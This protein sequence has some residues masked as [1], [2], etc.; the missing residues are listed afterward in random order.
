MRRRRRTL[1][2]SAARRLPRSAPGRPT[3][4]GRPRRALARREVPLR[5]V[6]A[7][8]RRRSS[9]WPFAAAPSRAGR[10]RRRLRHP[11]ADDRPAARGSRATARARRRHVGAGRRRRF[12]VIDTRT[13][14]SRPLRR[15]T[16]ASR[17][18]RSRRTGRRCTSRSTSTRQREPLRRARVRPRART[19]APGRIADKAQPSWV[20]EGS[21][22]RARRAATVAGSTRSSAPGGYPFVHALDT[23]R[24]VAHCIGLPWTAATRRR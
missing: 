5:R 23:V 16:A 8:A 9:A 3:S 22:R 24:G 18:T 15:C 11:A 20:M 19:P 10:P 7:D 6:S 1:S 17:T 14:A 4:P 21:R 13:C 12:A 2:Q